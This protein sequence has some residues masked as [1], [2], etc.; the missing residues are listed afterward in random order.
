M[1]KD[2]TALLDRRGFKVS[3]GIGQPGDYVI[4]RAFAE[5]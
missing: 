4:E 2:T 5:K 1:M 3:P